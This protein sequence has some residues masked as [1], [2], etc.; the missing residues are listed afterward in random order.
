MYV[1][2]IQFICHINIVSD[3]VMS[4]AHFCKRKKKKVIPHTIEYLQ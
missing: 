1:H 2:V 4:H 3:K